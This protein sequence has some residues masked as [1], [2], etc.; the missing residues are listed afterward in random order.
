MFL[1]N[2]MS[3]ISD[4]ARITRIAMP[5]SHNSATMGMT[6]FARCQNGSLYSQYAHGVRAF[7]IRLKADKKGNLLIAHGVLSGMP[8]EAAFENLKTILNESNEFFVISVMT[9]MNQKVGPISL[10]YNGNPGETSRLIREYLSPEKYA[11]TDIGNIRE[12]TMG[13]IRKSGKKYIIINENREYDY[14]VDCPYY[15]PWSSVVF[16]YKTPKFAKEI[17]KYLSEKDHEGFMRFQTQQ[18][19]N[20]GTENGWTKWPDDLDDMVRHYFAQIID[21]VAADPVML[22]RVNIVAGD[23]M[24]RDN[25]KANKILSLSLLKGIVKK[26]LISEYKEAISGNR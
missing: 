2:W 3:Y 19:P 26:E 14:S 13:D 11:L 5:G 16:G 8:A 21:D 12:L 4:D 1:K 23:F 17:L 20:P 9:Y 7:D 6:K 24:C 15:D 25:M 22:D 18:T 10:S